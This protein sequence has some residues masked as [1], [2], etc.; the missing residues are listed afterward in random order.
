MDIPQFTVQTNT[1][2]LLN[3]L[4]A[5]KNNCPSARFYQA[6]SSEMFGRCVDEDGYQRES[7]K[8]SNKPM[9]VL[10]FLDIIW[11]STTTQNYLQ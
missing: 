2:G 8:M 1:I 4:E 5:Y 11:L 7:T 3:I 6:S 9:D 10:K